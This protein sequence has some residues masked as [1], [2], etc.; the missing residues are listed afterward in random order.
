MSR[1]MTKSGW[2]V[3]IA[4]LA[5]L[6][7]MIFYIVTSTTGYLATAAVNPLPIICSAAAIALMLLL[8]FAEEKQTAI[9]ADLCVMGST[10]LLIVSFALFCLSRVTLAAD[11]YFIP[12]NYPASEATALHTS[13]AGAVLYLAAIIVMIVIAFAG[14]GKREA[15]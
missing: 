9:L 3:C 14:D 6:A 7:G 4:A 8:V 12:V 13:I 15:S 2:T 1:K 11:V 5:A 10:V